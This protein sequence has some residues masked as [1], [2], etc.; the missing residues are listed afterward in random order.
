MFA[1]RFMQSDV[2]ELQHWP[3]TNVM[4]NLANL[5]SALTRKLLRKY[6]HLA[7]TTKHATYSTTL[8]WGMLRGT[9]RLLHA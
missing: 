1:V 5:E 6:Q 4:N 2:G 8:G 7:V 9:S 3:T